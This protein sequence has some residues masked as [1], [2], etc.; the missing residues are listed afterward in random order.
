MRSTRPRA[1]GAMGRLITTPG[2]AAVVAS[3]STE[4]VFPL[5]FKPILNQE[6]AKKN[7]CERN[8]ARRLTAAMHERYPD[9]KL[10]PRYPLS[11]PNAAALL[12]ALSPL[13]TLSP[14]ACWA[15]HESKTPGKSTQ[16]VQGATF[17]LNDHFV[18]SD[19]GSLWHPVSK[20]FLNREL[21]G[22]YYPAR[23]TFAE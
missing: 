21:L 8:A 5:D 3:P 1:R 6:G 9:L 10:I 12:K 20:V 4:E 7:N 14:N 17:P 2:W 19:S 18:P 11:R 15:T 22:P 23:L 16:S 13:K